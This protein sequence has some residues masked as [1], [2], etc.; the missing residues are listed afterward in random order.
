MLRTSHI[1]NHD[2]FNRI[3]DVLATID[4]IFE[5]SVKIFQDDDGLH[6]KGAAKE[7]GGR[8]TIN[9]VTIEIGRAHV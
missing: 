7:I 4:R 2:T 8:R 3:A 6:F 1:L 5:I 9:F